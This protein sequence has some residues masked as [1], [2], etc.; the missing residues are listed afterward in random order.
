MRRLLRALG[1]L[2]GREIEALFLSPISYGVLTVGL[3]LNGYSFYTQLLVAQGNVGESVRIFF[4]GNPLF[5]MVLI[6]LPPLFTMRLF[7]EERRLNTLEMLL[8][9]PVAEL[10]V[11]LAK[12]LAGLFFYLALWL[13]SLFYL[14]IVKSY[15]AIPAVGQLS[16]SYLGIVLLGAVFVS[17]GL[18]ASALT[19]SQILAAV[20]STV[21]NL[22][23]L[24]VPALSQFTRSEK[25][26]RFFAELSVQAHFGDSFGKGVLDLGHVS[27]YLVATAV[28]LF[29]TVRVIEAQRWR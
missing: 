16:T 8:T 4:G 2:L 13:P 1:V 26:E 22:L 18:L 21:F 28:F 25:V 12:F 5:W 15:G 23:V 7:A 6:F 14:A 19:S 24:I 20:C 17:A 9:A 10:E 3:F 11:V 29:W 27:F